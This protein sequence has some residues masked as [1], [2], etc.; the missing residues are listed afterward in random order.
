MRMIPLGPQYGRWLVCVVIGQVKTKLS[1]FDNRTGRG[2]SLFDKVHG[3]DRRAPLPL[4][5]VLVRCFG[6]S[7][8]PFGISPPPLKKGE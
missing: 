4:K 2:S 5:K 1:L 6:I 8:P 7:S 3:I